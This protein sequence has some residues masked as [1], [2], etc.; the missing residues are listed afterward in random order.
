MKYKYY[1]IIL[2]HVFL[3]SCQREL[4]NSYTSLTFEVRDLT[5]SDNSLYL[6]GTFNQWNPGHPDYLLEKVGD[7]WII[8]IHVQSVSKLEYKFTRGRWESVEKDS[9]ERDISN[10][11]HTI[12]SE[13]DTIRLII[14]CWGS[15]KRVSTMTGRIEIIEN[16]FVP[17]FNGKRTLRVLLPY[18]YYTNDSRHYPVIYM[19]DG[20]NLFDDS[21]SFSGE[22]GI[23][24]S[25]KS[26]FDDDPDRGYVVVGIDN[27]P[28]RLS[29]YSPW[30][31]HFMHYH[32]SG[33][34]KKY[35]AFL[36]ETLKPYIDSHYRTVKGQES[37]MIAGSSMGGLISLYTGLTYPDK[38]GLIGSMSS[39]FSDVIVGQQLKAYIQ[40]KKG[41]I[42]EHLRIYLDI[43]T[44]ESAETPPEQEVAANQQVYALLKEII[45]DSVNVTLRIIP[46]GKHR[47]SDW[48]ERFPEMLRWLYEF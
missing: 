17:Q 26:L 23:D 47:E 31:F 29:E 15:G 46:G 43:G 39:T 10:R 35:A 34:G 9:L 11:I 13:K 6:S 21:T 12:Q 32:S 25:L 33:D 5:G 40:S 36:A 28:D 4:L 14:P 37:T 8:T 45:P 24:E 42:P 30:P 44:M 27:G 1:L 20:Q 48:R 41:E 16:F 3:F 18:D 7:I 38:F 19:H 22:W 2:C